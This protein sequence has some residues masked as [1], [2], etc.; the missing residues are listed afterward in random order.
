VRVFDLILVLC[1]SSVQGEKL[2]GSLGG[3]FSKTWKP[4]KTRKITGPMIGRADNHQQKE[5]PA[6]R[7][8]LGLNG[9]PMKKRSGGSGMHDQTTV[10]GQLDVRTLSSS[11]FSF[12]LSR[13]HFCML[14]YLVVYAD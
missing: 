5:S 14:F 13:K 8:A 12:F 11:M 3:V 1:C 4:K 9:E 2:L 7:E 10:R 6:D